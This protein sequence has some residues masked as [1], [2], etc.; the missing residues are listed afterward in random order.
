MFSTVKRRWEASTPM[1]RAGFVLCVATVMAGA[2]YLGPA[3]LRKEAAM[4]AAILAVT[5]WIAVAHEGTNVRLGRIG[6]EQNRKQIGTETV[7]RG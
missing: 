7:Y 4:L 2:S 3:A 1:G 6:N 5:F